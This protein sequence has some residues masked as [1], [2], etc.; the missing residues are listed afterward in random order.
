MRANI[1]KFIFIIV[2]YS[3]SWSN[4]VGQTLRGRVM[5]VN[6][7]ESLAFAY[8]ILLNEADSV[9]ISG[10]VTDINGYFSLTTSQS[11]NN[12]L[13]KIQYMGYEPII[14]KI[15]SENVGDILLK[16]NVTALGEVRVIAPAKSFRMVDGGISA[17]IQNSRLKDMGSLSDILGQLPF[18]IKDQNSYTVFG[19]GTPIFYINNRLVRND[20]ELQQ[21][22]S[23][24]IK[25]ITVITSPGAEYDSSVNAI[26]K[27]ETLRPV[28]EGF[29]GD[30]FTYNRYNSKFSTLNNI[31]LNYR[32]DK[33]DI[34]SSFGYADM[35]FPK[36]RI[37]T[38]TIA[39]NNT[40]TL[41]KSNSKENDSFRHL[42][43]KIGFNYLINTNHSFG[44]CYEYYSQPKLSGKYKKNIDVWK[45]QYEEDKLYSDQ[46]YNGDN[47]YHYVNLYYNGTLNKWL[48]I[49][50]DADY[51]TT[52]AM[53]ETD[54]TDL[55][56]DKTTEKVLTSNTASSDFYA[57][58]IVLNSPIWKGNLV[59]GTEISHTENKQNS[60]VIENEDI[61]GIIPSDNDVRQNL[62]AGFISFG[63]SFK[64][65]S[66]E[67]GFRFENVTSRYIQNGME[68][69]DQSK[70]YR[71][72]FPNLRFSYRNDMFQT[73]ISY[74][75]IIR[76]PGY[77]DLRSGI[78]YLAPYSYFS[79][80]PLL[81]PSYQQSLTLQAMWKKFTFMTIYSHYKDRFEEMLPQ[82]YLENSILLKPVNI[83]KSQQLSISLNYAPTLG[84]W[85][86]NIEL[87]MTKGYIKY[88]TPSTSYNKP[89]FSTSFRNSFQLRGWQ[90][91]VDISGRTKGHRG[92]EYLEHNSWNTS[93]YVNKS[94]LKN[95]LSVNMTVSDVFDTSNDKMSIAVGHLSAYYDN[96]MYRR[97]IQFRVS[98]RFNTSKNRYKGSKASD[99][100]DRL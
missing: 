13:L 23:K 88:G 14:T 49:K 48:T 18:V 66:G 8:V 27:I 26:I 57:T 78:S 90:F 35:S 93:L 63:K 30:L 44:S 71:N 16:P 38:N 64:Q 19:K 46:Y 70:D 99:E 60:A 75:N 100:L 67:I 47:K 95:S 15:V 20:L 51:K 80:N 10:D 96:S 68:V 53:N 76:R 33:V 4:S 36:D 28:G 52:K 25:K 39:E 59:Y 65:F 61:P 41:I 77:S 62:I 92:V 74:R 56:E 58:K 97:N 3:F 31:S 91:G 5:D 32:K 2:L 85:K 89:L 6:T 86:P 40:S 50:I 84:I 34:F 79:G 54:V 24:D 12:K 21:I 43:P 1:F 22:S 42:I 83:E 69:K 29:S 73:E 87:G 37:I 45:D 98:Y 72:L 94:F 7:S 17:D 55:K 81:Q 11:L 82:L 9:F